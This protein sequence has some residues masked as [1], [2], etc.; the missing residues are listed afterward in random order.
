[1]KKILLSVLAA[2]FILAG[3]GKSVVGPLG[4]SVPAASVVTQNIT[5]AAGGVVNA[6][7]VNVNIPA[8]ALAQNT[9]ISVAPLAE[10][11]LPALP[12]VNQALVAAATFGPEGTTFSTPVTITF[13][14]KEAATPG[15]TMVLYLYSATSGAWGSAG[16]A[17][18]SADGLSAVASVT[19]FS[20]YSVMK[21]SGTK[22]AQTS[23]LHN[24]YA[25]FTTGYAGYFDFEAGAELTGAGP[26]SGGDFSFKSNSQTDCI[27]TGDDGATGGIQELTGVTSLDS[28]TSAPTTG[29][30]G[31]LD[32]NGVAITTLINKVYAVKT[33]AGAYVALQITQIDTATPQPG[34]VKF[35][36]R[37]VQ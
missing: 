11:S 26:W 3:C 28:V 32:Y 21:S 18:V 5:A 1:M 29:Y 37:Y 22:Y 2:A 8:G 12:P 31:G 19:H 7:T 25:W 20:T 30:V 10:G 23:T 16:N 24:H 36:W 6:G 27:F 13:S 9:A 35:K 4:P 17:T 15:A 14:L 34:W 33:T